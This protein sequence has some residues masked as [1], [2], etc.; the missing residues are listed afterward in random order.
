[1]PQWIARSSISRLFLATVL[2][3]GAASSS[4]HSYVPPNGFVPDENTAIRIA[5]A[6]LSP[7]YGEKRVSQE[8]PFTATLKNGVWTVEGHLPSGYNLGGVAEVQI[9]KVDGRVLRVTHSK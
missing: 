8:R 9:S 4:E 2:F 7:I 3:W 6:V 1:M 5:E